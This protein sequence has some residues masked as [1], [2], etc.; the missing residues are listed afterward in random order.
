MKL[1]VKRLRVKKGKK[2]T[3]VLFF[4]DWHYGH[5]TAVSDK[6]I[7]NL[8]YCL[9][10][11]VYVITMGDLVECSIKSSIG[12]V[13][14]QLHDPQNQMDYIR[15]ILRP[16][17]ERGLILNMYNGNHEYRIEKETSL[18]ITQNIA[19]ELKVPYG[20][21]AGWNLLRVGNQNYKVYGTHGSSGSKHPHTKLKAAIDVSLQMEAEHV[22]VM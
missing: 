4:G 16:L 1:N 15:E 13:Y 19:R 2:Y 9:D 8:K 21:Y 3:E 12:N 11:D 20:G 14:E 6:A 7:A 18:K 17:A 5:P 22:N 10:N